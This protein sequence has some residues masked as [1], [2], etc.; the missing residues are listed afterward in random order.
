MNI[1]PAT[2]S[3]GDSELDIQHQQH[4]HHTQR[5][6][7]EEQQFNYVLNYWTS[8]TERGAKA[9]LYVIIVGQIMFHLDLSLLSR[10]ELNMC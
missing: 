5:L 7:P 6:E 1:V 3:L 9:V 8:V 4:L 2:G 10:I